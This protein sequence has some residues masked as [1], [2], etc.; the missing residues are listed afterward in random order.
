MTPHRSNFLHLAAL[1][2]DLARLGVAAERYFA[3]DPNTSLLKL[4]QFAELMAQQVAARV[5]I[6]LAEEDNQ[7]SLLSRLKAG[8]WLP[9]ETAELF[10]WI[11][12]AGNDANH[13]FNGDHRTALEGLKVSTQLGFWF[14]RTFKNPDFRGGTFV[15]PSPPK[16]EATTL[17]QE[18]AALQ[19]QLLEAQGQLQAE[20]EKAQSV[21]KLAAEAQEEAKL[22]EDL[23]HET[24]SSVAG[25]KAQLAS[26]QMHAVQQSSQ[27]AADI[28][29]KA[30][31]AA[32]LI[33]LDEKAT[34]ALI[35]QQLRDAGWE[36]DSQ[37]LRFSEGTRPEA[38]RHLAIAEWPTD[39]GPADYA[40]FI[41]TECVA[42]IEAKRRN[43][44][45]ASAIDQAKRY[46]RG[47][48]AEGGGLL[49]A[50]WGEFRIPF[51]FSTNGR[52]FQQQ[53]K[54][55]SGTWF[56][57]LRRPQNLRKA[58]DGW[59]TPEG[60]RE[61]LKKNI[62]GA[63]AKLKTVG[64]DFGFPLRDYQQSAILSVEAAIQQGK[65]ECLVAMATGTGKTKTC[66]A[67]LYRLLRANRFRRIL[68]LVDRS[69]L[70]E[71]A[72]NA[73]KETRMMSLN[74]FADDFGIKEIDEQQPEPD[75]KVHIA[76][77]QGL[78]QRI[79]YAEDGGPPVDAYDCIVVDECHRGYL[80]D[81]EMS[82][83]EVA[84]RDQDEY[85]S[86]Y[87]RV[88]DHFDAVK[89]G[90]TA[91]PALH[92][93]EIFG[94]PVYVYS[95][96]EAVLDGHLIDHEPAQLIRTRLSS[97]GIHWKAGE[98]VPVYNPQTENV[99]LFS[100][101]DQ[102]DFEVADFNKKVI[103]ENFN[104]VVCEKLVECI[105]PYGPEKTLIF[106]A[107]DQHADMVVR[108]LKEVFVDAGM[109]VNDDAILKITGSADKPLELIRRLRNEKN[110]AIAVTVD[111][112]T[113]GV[114]VPQ[115]S[116]L[117]FLRR[118]NSRILYEQ[119]LG[120]ATRRCDEID[121]EVFR[122]YDA[123]DIYSHLEPVNSMKPVVQ[124][125]NI[126][127]AQLVR[128][129]IEHTG[130]EM[131]E[132][133]CLQL[134]AKWQRKKRHLT[135][136]QQDRLKQAGFDPED[137]AGFLKKSST[138]EVAEWFV[139]NPDLGELLDKK[140]DFPANPQLISHHEDKLVS[141]EAHY[142]KPDDYL[143]RFQQFIKE[144]GNE[145][146]ALMAVVQRPRE[147]TRA[148]LVQLSTALEKAGFDERALTDAWAKKTNQE[149]AARILGFVR[150][151]ALGDALKPY[152]QR[153]DEA[154]QKIQATRP[155]SVNQQD[156]LKR[157]AAQVKANIL[158]DESIF[159]N[160]PLRERGGYKMANKVFDGELSTLLA[161]M[162]ERIWQ[163]D[164]S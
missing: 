56:C 99:D 125:P 67:L 43:K 26:L 145:I 120:R 93:T 9:R 78:V 36:A 80:L 152:A 102:L 109:D 38:A 2:E 136:S 153:V 45:V 23:A 149:I 13:Q 108:L 12:K 46:A 114:D 50:Q 106:C 65:T 14:H 70:G 44:D 17:K 28:Q 4:R 71:Q 163:K 91:T 113:T 74:T 32:A 87:R 115:I 128:E 16:D 62:D 148:D 79:L 25:L 156:W 159:N 82:D 27:Q 98:E 101:P 110:P 107:T 54:E 6:Y 111:L 130:T 124:N 10:H 132:Q 22:W 58:L 150:Q 5:G 20:A 49:P 121:K 48:H 144:K 86:K 33:S 119:M 63:E 112:L 77:V 29:H 19:Q 34:R 85:I 59:Y 133:A 138:K 84:Y 137:F 158:L 64:F 127:F 30:V 51:V 41:G 3:E 24:D 140:R 11:R 21:A 69:A 131:A 134:L 116:N 55:V 57:D 61:E 68:F 157:I 97:E 96:R 83:T 53:F 147:L 122:I 164:A 31:K 76:T 104:K 118:V 123:V 81:R 103:T 42:V 52:P 89:I 154:V 105:T 100:A 60:L 92:T 155:L 35:D 117:V 142:G 47:L 135:D 90:L 129:I 151:A 18:L 88:I 146:P 15:P 75:T 160:G 39:S 37:D 94:K 66:I 8:G 161:D 143:D 139:K 40:L 1:Q 162:N 72:A 7:A 73:F 126:G 95:Y 141:M